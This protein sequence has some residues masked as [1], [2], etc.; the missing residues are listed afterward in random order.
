MKGN[1][2]MNDIEP[3]ELPLLDTE[4]KDDEEAASQTVDALTSYFRR[5]SRG[6]VI[7]MPRWA[8]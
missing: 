6:R 3:E 2:E 7:D 8:Q 5:T 4:D 1:K